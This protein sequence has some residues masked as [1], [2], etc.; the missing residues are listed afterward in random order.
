[1]CKYTHRLWTRSSGGINFHNAINF[2]RAMTFYSSWESI[3]SFFVAMLNCTLLWVLAGRTYRAHSQWPQ[4]ARFPLWVLCRAQ[5]HVLTKMQG[6][7]SA[8]F[9]ILF[10][11]SA[12]I[13][14]HIHSMCMNFCCRL[15]SFSISHSL[16]PFF[17][18]FS[19][20]CFY[21]MFFC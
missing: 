6:Y 21:F 10:A 8:L 9:I 20:V 17:G 16:F 19:T 1:M 5:M 4:A 13:H 11:L 2:N 14:G 15:H 7:S 18:V 3:A 12:F